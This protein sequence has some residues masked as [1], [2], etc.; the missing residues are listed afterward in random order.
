MSENTKLPM[1][2]FCWGS[3]GCD[4][5]IGHVEEGDPIH[6]CGVIEYKV[7]QIDYD[8]KTSGTSIAAH[9]RYDESTGMV[10]TGLW[11]DHDQFLGW[12]KPEPMINLG[13]VNAGT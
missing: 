2:T 4:K 1:C 3:H 8:M 12:D 5:E 7:G 9:S 11:G 13:Y 10:I 6:E